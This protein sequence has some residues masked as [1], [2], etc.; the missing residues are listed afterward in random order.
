MYSKKLFWKISDNSQENNCNGVWRFLKIWHHWRCFPVNFTKTLETIYFVEHLRMVR[1]VKRFLKIDCF[2][3]AF[4]HVQRLMFTQV[5]FWKLGT[6]NRRALAKTTNSALRKMYSYSAF[7]SSVFYR[8]RTEFEDL[9]SKNLFEYEDLQVKS[10]YSD[11]MRE[12][13]KQANP[14]YVDFPRSGS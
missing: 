1:S 10:P 12:N 6:E 2:P 5:L 7:F 4:F 3:L 9:Q 8:V 11:W 13:T 14:E